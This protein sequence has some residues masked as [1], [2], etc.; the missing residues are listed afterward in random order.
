M[1]GYMLSLWAVLAESTLWKYWNTANHPF[2]ILKTCIA[3]T[4]AESI[5]PFH[6]L[7]QFYSHAYVN[8][9]ETWTYGNQPNDV[10][11]TWTHGN[12]PKKPVAHDAFFRAGSVAGFSY[13]APGM[14]W[15]PCWGKGSH[16]VLAALRESSQKAVRPNFPAG[17]PARHP[18]RRQTANPA[19]KNAPCATGLTF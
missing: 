15:G 4:L 19:R 14:G 5:R 17:K 7:G 3:A 9:R 12:Q 2:F 10:R 11:L 6:F 13:L 8:T 16:T 18:A 1:L